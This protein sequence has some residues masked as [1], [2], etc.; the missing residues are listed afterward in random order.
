MANFSVLS[1]ITSDIILFSESIDKLI[2]SF[3]KLSSLETENMA[4]KENVELM[5]TITTPPKET[6]STGTFNSSEK[7]FS[8]LVISEKLDELIK[9]FTNGVDLNMN[10]AKMAE[11]VA[12]NARKS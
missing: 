5:G 8:F 6:E 4:I 9:I 2:E 7:E 10:G 12:K 3:T 11:F 1:S